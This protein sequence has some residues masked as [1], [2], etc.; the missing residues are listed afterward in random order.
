MDVLIAED[1][2]ETT[3]LYRVALRSRGHEVTSTSDGL[4]CLQVYKDTANKVG[5]ERLT[6]YDVVVLDYRMPKLDGLE[7][8][9]AILKINPQQRI[10]FA[11]AYVRDTLRDSVKN[12]QRIVELIEKPFEP[13]SLVELIENT[14][15]IQEL[16][17]INSLVTDMDV[18]HASISGEYVLKGIRRMNSILGTTTINALISEVEDRGIVFEDE[19]R[20]SARDLQSLLRSVFGDHVGTFLM[21]FFMGYF[22]KEPANNDK[23]SSLWNTR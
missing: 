19:E 6:P 9:K 15:A 20:Y 2:T 4:E 11:S 5:K 8:A 16:T 21:R 13:K 1:N 3:N 12:L 23:N 17:E 14:R 18:A 7:T 10:I 22:V